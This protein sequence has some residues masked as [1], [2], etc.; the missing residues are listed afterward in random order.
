MNL[1]PSGY[2]S[3]ASGSVKTASE[4]GRPS[5]TSSDALTLTP[6]KVSDRQRSVRPS[7]QVKGISDTSDASD[8][9]PDGSGGAE[10]GSPGNLRTPAEHLATLR[11][12]KLLLARPGRDLCAA[13]GPAAA[14]KAS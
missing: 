8:G 10:G 7:P 5:D 13:C 14:R 6:G 4:L 11:D 3:E 1:S 2:P 12:E 9:Y